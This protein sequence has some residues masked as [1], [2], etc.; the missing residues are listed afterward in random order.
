MKA[1][2]ELRDALKENGIGR[3]STRA[4]IIET[5]F[6][7]NYI[8]KTRKSLFP[9]PTG[10]ELIGLI[11]ED[12]LKSAE[13]T[14]RWEKLLREIERQEYEPADFINGLKEQIEEIV[15]DVLCDNSNRHVTMELP[16]EK[17]GKKTATT[18]A[19]EQSLKPKTPRIRAGSTCPV[20]G[21]GKVIKG[22]TA[23]G[24]SRWKEG[25]T[26]RKPFKK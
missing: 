10:T 24:C 12:L 16:S 11:K 22:K 4:A 25:C 8:R 19:G 7:R 18:G 23:Y 1:S 20:C 5:L 15:H 13:L 26:F 9:T 2:H 14:G 21:Q 17:G 6:R 3:P